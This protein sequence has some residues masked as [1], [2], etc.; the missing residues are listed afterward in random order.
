MKIHIESD[1]EL[2]IVRIMDEHGC[3]AHT[4]SRNV[5]RRIRDALNSPWSIIG[6]S[7]SFDHRHG[8]I[9]EVAWSHGHVGYIFLVRIGDQLEEWE[10]EQCQLVE[11]VYGPKD[12]FADDEETYPAGPTLRVQRERDCYRELLQRLLHDAAHSTDLEDE[13]KRALESPELI[14]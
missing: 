7:V 14:V 2:G 11:Q 12:R 5:A 1:Q 9:Q 4:K 6:Q 13:V 10:A 8:V 3:L